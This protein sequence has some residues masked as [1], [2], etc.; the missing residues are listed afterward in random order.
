MTST[1]TLAVRF[2]DEVPLERRKHESQAIR[3][4]YA[5]LLP[6]IIE[7]KRSHG[8]FAPSDLTL[9]KKKYLF[10]DELTMGQ[11]QQTI[12]KRVKL[13]EVEGMFMYGADNRLIPLAKPLI[14]YFNEMVDPDGFLYLYICKESAFG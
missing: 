8:P 14:E 5:R 12:R 7:A 10:P 4:K 2:K 9:D 11:V 1:N 13:S 3:N 6:V